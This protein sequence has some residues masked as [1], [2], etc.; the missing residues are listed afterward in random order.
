LDWIGLSTNPNAIHILEKNLDKVYWERLSSNTNAIHILDKNLH[1]VN[2]VV[3]SENPNAIHLISRLLLNHS[4]M[5]EN[6]K[7]FAEELVAYVFHSLL[8]NSISDNLG[9]DLDELVEMY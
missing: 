5:K 3:L 6:M 7:P 2:Y 8:L 9:I 4:K 1:K